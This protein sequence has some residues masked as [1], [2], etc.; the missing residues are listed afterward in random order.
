MSDYDEHGPPDGSC[1]DC[2]EPTEEEHHWR[3]P[4]CFA[5]E[6]GW[7]RPARP[8]PDTPPRSFV[9]GLADLRET[10]ET[11]YVT[12][13]DRGEGRSVALERQLAGRPA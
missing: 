13:T 12:S 4:D 6:Q 10:V 8:T 11:N 3:C 7:T 9:V 5:R 2:G 1:V